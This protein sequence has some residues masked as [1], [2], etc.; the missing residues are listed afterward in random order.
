MKKIVSLFVMVA[1]MAS[2]FGITVSFH[3]CGKQFKHINL[4]SDTEKGCCGKN[5]HKTNCCKD[6]VVNAKYNDDHTV[7]GKAIAVKIFFASG[8]LPVYKDSKNRLSEA[9]CRV[10]AANDSSPPLTSDFPIYLLNRA[11]RI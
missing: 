1:Y 5:E 11:L 9:Q 4:T 3:H 8:T 10:L 6:V 2:A 7:S